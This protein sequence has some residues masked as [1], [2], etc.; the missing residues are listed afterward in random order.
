MFL[1]IAYATTMV[2]AP[3]C[4]CCEIYSRSYVFVIVNKL[5]LF[6]T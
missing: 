6:Y 5:E 1:T 4:L 3:W 2:G